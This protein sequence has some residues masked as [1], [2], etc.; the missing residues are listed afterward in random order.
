MKR[1][2]GMGNDLFVDFPAGYW[3]LA[4][5]KHAT[6]PTLLFHLVTGSLKKDFPRL[7]E[8]VPAARGGI[9]Q[10]SKRLFEVLCTEWMDWMP[11]RK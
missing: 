1:R 8:L 10:P 9:T 6:P 2:N 11:H 7:G 3:L 5:G 4:L